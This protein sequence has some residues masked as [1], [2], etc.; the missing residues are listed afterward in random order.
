[1]RLDYS[2]YNA[3]DTANARFVLYG[4]NLCYNVY[5]GPF[6]NWQK[7]WLYGYICYDYDIPCGGWSCSQIFGKAYQTYVGIDCVEN[8]SARQECQSLIGYN[9]CDPSTGQCKTKTLPTVAECGGDIFSFGFCMMKS[10]F[11]G[12]GSVALSLIAIMIT[13]GSMMTAT[14]STRKWQI[15]V[16]LG[17]GIALMFL[18][19]GWLPS[20]VAVLWILSLA[21]LF[22]KTIWFNK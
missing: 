12:T 18:I 16:G 21:V 8:V 1:L 13:G 19:M 15:G 6:G 5:V 9:A 22:M 4:A 7:Y 11:G 3:G 2:G 10:T 20:Y 17:M 14:I